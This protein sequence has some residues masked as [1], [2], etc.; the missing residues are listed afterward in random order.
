MYKLPE[1]HTKLQIQ[2]EL[3]IFEFIEIG[4]IKKRTHSVLGYKTRE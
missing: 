1:F 3:N 4:I 2:M